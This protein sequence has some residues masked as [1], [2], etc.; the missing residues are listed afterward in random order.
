MASIGQN[1]RNGLIVGLHSNYDGE[2]DNKS[3]SPLSDRSKH[4][5]F[6]LKDFGGKSDKLSTDVQ[7]ESGP[8]PETEFLEETKSPERNSNKIRT[9]SEA[10]IRSENVG[11]LSGKQNKGIRISSR[12]SSK[13]V[14]FEDPREPRAES[15]PVKF[16][17]T[18]VDSD[19]E[20]RMS[21][22]SNES[23]ELSVFAGS[24]S[25]S[26]RNDT[27][28]HTSFTNENDDFDETGENDMDDTNLDYFCVDHMQL[29]SMKAIRENHN[30]CKNVVSAL[31]WAE[32]QQLEKERKS[33]ES[34]LQKFDTFAGIMIDERKDL[35]RYLTERKED[36]TEEA[37]QL[38]EDLVTHL[39]KKQKDFTER[40][41]AL[42]E[43]KMKV[44]S[45]QI[46]RCSMIQKETSTSMKQLTVSHQVFEPPRGKT[47]NMVSERYDT[48]RAVQAQKLA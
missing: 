11:E 36:V 46:K 38:M 19:D 33:T 43:S 20:P 12:A 2:L 24:G 17:L 8:D 48:N 22:M 29:C 7:E 41:E 25:S 34:Q 47:N 14:S 18:D 10:S 42:H 1:S 40:F 9:V 28:S 37:L 45:D 30:D 16:E 31:E 21:I 3:V 4:E 15:R 32:E 13:S 44:I 39:L 35:K 23:T 26:D 5:Q 6:E 27:P